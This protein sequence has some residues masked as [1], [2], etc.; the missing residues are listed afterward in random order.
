V[1]M[2]RSGVAPGPAA[3]EL[4]RVIADS[5]G[6][7][8][9]GL[10]VY[11]GHIRT[12]DPEVRRRETAAAFAPVDALRAEL[13]AAGLPVP[14]IVAGGTP[15]FPM[16]ARRD[17]V[18]CS[19]GT[20]VLWDHS[21]QTKFP[22]LDFVNAALVL[23]RVVSKPAQDRLCL[24]LGYKAVS[25]DNADP[26]VVFPELSEAKM[27]VHSEEH[28]A[29]ETPRANEY[30]V[31][32]VLYGVP[33]HICPT[34]ALYEEAVVVENGRAVDHWRVVARDRKLTI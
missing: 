19:P 34:V 23:T 1:G 3:I 21:Y 30:A 6:L 16:H 22:D 2:H 33:F 15:T 8:P 20:C 5:P 18:E 4:Y 27:I 29:I 14:R 25:P 24:D 10:H 31:G 7:A 12:R 13:A 9:G 32:D 26:R 17:D 28:L 11:D